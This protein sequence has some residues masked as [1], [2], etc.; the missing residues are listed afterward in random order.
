MES[1]MEDQEIL[2]KE[3]QLIEDIRNLF[4]EL[5]QEEKGRIAQGSYGILLNPSNHVYVY[6]ANELVAKAHELAKLNPKYKADLLNEIL[7]DEVKLVELYDYK[8]NKNKTK[9]TTKSL[10]EMQ[11]LMHDATYHLQLY[12]LPVL[13]D[14]Q[15]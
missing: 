15:L 9:P 11:R 13:G 2:R 8:W 5:I 7:R 4:G 6:K 12:F 1:D 10:N 3:Q 14:I